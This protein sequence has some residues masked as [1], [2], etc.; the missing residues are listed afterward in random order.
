MKTY[1]KKS[2]V[3]VFILI[4]WEVV[5][6]LNWIEQFMLPKFSQVVYALFS[7]FPLLFL[8]MQ[9][10]LFETIIGLMIS[11]ILGVGMAFLMD[12]W[13][14]FYELSYPLIV[15]IQ[16]IPII[17]IA[18]LLLLWFG[19]GYTPKIILVVIVCSFPIMLQVYHALMS[20]DKEQKNLLK[21]FCATEWQM[22]NYLKIPSVLPTFFSSLKIATSYAVISAVV[23]EWLGGDTGLGV[24]MIRVRK[25]FAFDKMFA[26]IILISVL[27][28]M[29]MGCV[30]CIE[31]YCMKYRRQKNKEEIGTR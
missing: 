30:S 13:Q 24:Y 11:V 16:T 3:I 15:L 10:T 17:S 29:L 21:L 22:I 27:T 7:D 23:S 5:T 1:F 8:H 6:T 31:K 20:I 12:K 19:I 25:S 28:F 9:T 2:I 4:L 18:P 26:T 14:L